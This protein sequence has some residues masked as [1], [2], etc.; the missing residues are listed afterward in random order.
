MIIHVLKSSGME[1]AM[2][3]VGQ[4]LINIVNVCKLYTKYMGGGQECK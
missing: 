4:C 3:H 2:S 1:S